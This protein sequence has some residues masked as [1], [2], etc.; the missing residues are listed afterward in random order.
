LTSFL[1][2]TL[3]RAKE[4]NEILGC[5]LDFDGITKQKAIGIKEVQASYFDYYG[6]AKFYSWIYVNQALRTIFLQTRGC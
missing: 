5:K 3:V 4:L 6:L 1:I 2:V